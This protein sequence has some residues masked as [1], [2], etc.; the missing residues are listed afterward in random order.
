MRTCCFHPPLA[1]I[2][3]DGSVIDRYLPTT[4]PASLKSDIEKALGA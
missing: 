4:G 1:V 3:K 2:G